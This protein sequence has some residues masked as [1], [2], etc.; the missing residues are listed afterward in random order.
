MIGEFGLMVI[1]G[2]VL[3]TPSGVTAQGWEGGKSSDLGSSRREVACRSGT[4]EKVAQQGN[5]V[6][7][8]HKQGIFQ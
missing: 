7:R 5:G 4:A 3:H 6:G 8:S 1:I 2:T